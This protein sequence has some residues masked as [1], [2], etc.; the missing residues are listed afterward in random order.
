MIEPKDVLAGIG[1]G[2][3]LA[4]AA[5]AIIVVCWALSAIPI[6]LGV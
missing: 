3:C 4:V 5:T 6:A 2:I 1:I